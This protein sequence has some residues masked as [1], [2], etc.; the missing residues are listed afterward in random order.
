MN[1]GLLEYSQSRSHRDRLSRPASFPTLLLGTP[2]ICSI[3]LLASL[4]PK[5][6]ILISQIMAIHPRVSAESGNSRGKFSEQSSTLEASRLNYESLPRKTLSALTSIAGVSEDINAQY[7]EL[8]LSHE[9]I[10]SAEG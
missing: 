3:D 2:E 7:Q 1:V 9:R 6:T 4:S 10:W 5:V 8:G